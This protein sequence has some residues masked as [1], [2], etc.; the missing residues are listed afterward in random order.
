ML[1]IIKKGI[2]GGMHRAIYRY[3]KVNDKYMKDQNHRS[4]CTG[5]S[6]IFMDWQCHK[7]CLWMVR[8]GEITSLIFTKTSYKAVMKTVTKDIYLKLMLGILRNFEKAHD[9]LPFLPE[10]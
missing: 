6:A 2:K 8:N 1:L 10:K 4:S 7:M 9:D 5:M 3:A